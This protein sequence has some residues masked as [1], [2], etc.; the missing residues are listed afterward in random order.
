MTKWPDVCFLMI[1]NVVD[2]GKET[3][4]WGSWAKSGSPDLR[5][6][7]IPHPVSHLIPF[8][9]MGGLSNNRKERNVGHLYTGRFFPASTAGHKI[10]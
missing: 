5:A 7:D 2:H 9:L 6:H 4:G 8:R 10:P 3:D 1:Y